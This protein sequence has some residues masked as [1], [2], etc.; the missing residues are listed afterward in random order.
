[1]GGLE[2][3]NVAHPKLAQRPF[4]TLILTVER[5]GYH[6]TNRDLLFH[7]LFHQLGGY[8]QLGAE[9]RVLLASLKVVGGGVGLEANGP[10]DLLV[11]PQAAYADHPTLGLADVSEP[12][13]S[14]M[15]GFLAPLAIPVLIYDQ[16]AIFGGSHS[17]G[18][19]HQLQPPCVNLP[20]VPPR[21][22]EKPLQAL[23]LLTLR[24]YHRLSV[25]KSAQCLV[26]LGG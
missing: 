14:Y 18:F 9:G 17:R 11:R 10:V 4:E 25:G 21:F 5:V 20:G 15:S 24:S 6:R 8:L 1:M 22:R 19:A 7:C 12:L 3:H 2:G 26:A 16:H 13:P 23:S